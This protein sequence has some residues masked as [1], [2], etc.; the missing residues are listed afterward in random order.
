V[1]HPRFKCTILAKIIYQTRLRHSFGYMIPD[2]DDR[3]GQLEKQKDGGASGTDTVSSEHIA[4]VVA[5][6]T[7]GLVE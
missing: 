5:R 6:W 7:G 1:R 3:L 2:F 4:E